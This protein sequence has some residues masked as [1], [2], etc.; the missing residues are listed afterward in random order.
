MTIRIIF[1]ALFFTVVLCTSA[2]AGKFNK[3]FSVG[4]AAPDW[5]KL[6]AIDGKIHSL[7]DFKRRQGRGGIFT[8]NHCP[9]AQACEE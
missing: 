4:D 5:E 8:C 3:Q 6:P 2:H 1:P 9:V 7:D